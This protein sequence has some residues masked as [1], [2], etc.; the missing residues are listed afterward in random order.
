VDVRT[1]T[2]PKARRADARRNISAILDAGAR[3]LARDPEAS[4]GDIAKAAGVG[5]VTLYGHFAS[6]SE[7]IDAVFAHTVER[8][9]AVLDAVD[10]TGD[11]RAALAR[12]VAASWRIV[13]EFRALMT[14]AQ[15]TLPGERIR[16]HHDVPLRRIQSILDRGRAEGVFRTDLPAAWLLATYYGVMHGAADE[17]NAGRL[18]E[19]DAPG[20]ITRTLL[21]AFTPPGSPVPDIA[22]SN[23]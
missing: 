22:A 15:R 7:L 13:D 1:P 9:D 23:R 10:L 8:A 18:S 19:E 16:G 14:A 11:P 2:E 20:V 12:L 17:I 3:C 4:L 6:R 21:A 5:R